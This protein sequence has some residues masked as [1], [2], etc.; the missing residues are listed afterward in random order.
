MDTAPEHVVGWCATEAGPLAEYLVVLVT[1]PPDRAAGIA[2]PLVEE[3]LCACVNIVPGLRSIYRWKGEL[4]DDGESLLVIKTRESLLEP[5]RA[6]VL[7]LHPYEVPEVLAL[8]VQAGN[9]DYL[10]WLTDSTQ[11]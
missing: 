1:C 5:L 11:R 7:Q 9:P 4:C 8:P 10:R 3:K 6:R 2:R